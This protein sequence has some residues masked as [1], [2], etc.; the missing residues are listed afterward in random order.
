MG[1][2]RFGTIFR[3]KKFKNVQV[4]SIPGY[5]KSLFI[6]CNG[7]F[8]Q[9][10]SKVFPVIE[11]HGVPI[12]EKEL[13]KIKKKYSKSGLRK[14]Y[15]KHIIDSLDEILDT[16]NP[17]DVLVIAP[18]GTANAAKQ[19]QQKG[20]RFS[21]KEGE[22]YTFD[23]NSLT[24]GTEVMIEID[25]AIQK[26]L[27]KRRKEG[28]LPPTTVYSSHMDPGEGEHKIFQYIREGIV[29]LSSDED[30]DDDED[31]EGANVIYGADGD[32]YIL[33]VLSPLDNI[34]LYRD[35]FGTLFSIEKFKDVIYELLYF[36]GCDEKRLF[37]DFSLLAIF[38]GN[39]FVTKFPNLPGTG[40]TLFEIMIRIY[41]RSK[42]HL[43]DSKNNIIWENFL[44]ILKR[45]GS[46]KVR[47]QE[48]TYLYAYDNLN[49]PVRDMDK[50]ITIKDHH[51]KIVT[52]E[53]GDFD[54]SKHTRTFDRKG[55]EK[56]WYERQFK[57]VDAS[58]YPSQSSK[59]GRGKEK[60]GKDKDIEFYTR[61]DVFNMCVD[62]LKIL[63]WVQY[64]YTRGYREVSDHFFYAYRITPLVH[65]LSYYLSTIIERDDEKILRKGIMK[66]EGGKFTITPIHQLLS[67][68]PPGSIDLIPSQFR[69]IYDHLKVI[70]PS[71]Y[72][73]PPAENTDAA[74]H[75]FPL[76]PPVNLELVNY[77]IVES[78]LPIPKKYEEV[79]KVS[80]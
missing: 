59:I 29:P 25:K 55:F 80:F 41:N 13:E 15:I 38:V 57:P 43:T 69:P 68:L 49:F 32:L 37:Q 35:N 12:P 14:A 54:P 16:F 65:N 10:K 71:V 72:I 23:G 8:H 77:Y 51:G 52:R 44:V 19:S 2:E 6:D 58:L 28:K 26:W 60:N 3:D 63:Q 7:I 70:N 5:V 62:Y 36:D 31:E 33:S 74:H 46:W 18:D 50:Y 17:R 30:E 22:Y 34:Y 20:R 66:G 47:G 73:C 9:S 1:I 67:V 42:E 11:E 61:K 48:D 53:E 45:L 4:K 40:K 64:Y 79:E 39:D 76:I 78:D 56:A 27:K 75:T 24:P 21:P